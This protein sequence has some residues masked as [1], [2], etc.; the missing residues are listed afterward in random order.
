[1]VREYSSH[2]TRDAEVYRIANGR[3]WEGEPSRAARGGG[4]R[5]RDWHSVLDL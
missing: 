3:C 1:M 2:S 4:C 5:V